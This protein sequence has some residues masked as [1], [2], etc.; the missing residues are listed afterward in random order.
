M[1]RRLFFIGVAS[2]VI[3]TGCHHKHEEGH[4][5]SHD[6]SH[7]TVKTEEAREGDEHE[8]SHEHSS[9]VIVLEPEKAEAAGV[10]ADTI[11]PGAFHGVITTGGKILSASGDETTIVATSAGVVS[12]SRP[13]TEGMAVGQGSTIFSI[14]SSGLQDG[15]VSQRARITY[16]TAKSEYERAQ[17]LIADKIIT[18]KE[19]L[20]AK[21][22][23]ENAELAYKA[24]GGGNGSKGVA[25]KSPAGGY[26]KECLVKAGDYVEV[27]QPMMV[28]TQNRHL[29]LRAE[30]PERDY[31][32]INQVSSAKFKTSYSDKVYDIKDLNGR[33]LS[34]GKTSGSSSSFI[35]V[36][37][38]FDN[39]SGLIPGAFA[40]VYL[41]TNDRSNVISVP[42]SA[43]T[44]EQGVHFVYIREDEECYRKQEV[45]LGASDGQQTE[46][47][48]GL[49]GGEVLVTEGAIHV[50]LASAG[51]S[52]P[53][54]T[55]N[56]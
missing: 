10:K 17:K 13:V 41:L 51:K 30:V 18:E 50:K 22:D 36:T 53:G 7:D 21:A 45:R 6:H 31:A 47:T 20:A 26:V 25:V 24:V 39:A 48:E 38:E 23:F 9:D 4:D 40:E 19:Y 1:N 49:K 54:H 56:H 44:E 3:L 35:P 12:L 43:L 8:E 29:Y 46:I 32:A 28:V 14:T 5:H 33:L 11:T 16:E 55:H 34:Y 42:V 37:F 27:G 2:A 52:I 15:D